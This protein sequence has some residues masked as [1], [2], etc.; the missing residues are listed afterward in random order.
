MSSPR[1]QAREFAMQMLFQWEMSPQDLQKLEK[2]FWKNASSSEDVEIYAN[3]LFEAT[4]RTVKDLDQV[5]ERYCEN[6]RFDRIAAID[7]AILRLALHE[8]A[9]GKTPL[10]SVINEALELAKKYS[11]QE[12]AGFVNG[13][14]DAAAKKGAKQK[15]ASAAAKRS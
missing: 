10:R 2:K 3:Q 6:W 11:G 12:S 8:M 5:I 14:L 13:I 4:V 9:V 7:R 15:P 1:F